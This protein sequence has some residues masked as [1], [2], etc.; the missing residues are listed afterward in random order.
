MVVEDRVRGKYID[1]LFIR[2][3]SDDQSLQAD[4]SMMLLS[5]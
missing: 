3:A 1:I 4:H 2:D 5:F